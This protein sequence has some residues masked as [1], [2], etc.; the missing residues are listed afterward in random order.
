MT[1]LLNSYVYASSPPPSGATRWRVRAPTVHLSGD[2]FAPVDVIFIAADTAITMPTTGTSTGSGLIEGAY[3]WAFDSD[4][5]TYAAVTASTGWIE[6]QFSAA[7]D[8]VGVWLSS[9]PHATWCRQMP[10]QLI[11]EYYNG[12]SWVEV[13]NQT[14]I[15]DWGYAE[16]RKF[17]ATGYSASYTA[18]ARKYWRV[19]STDTNIAGD[20]MACTELELRATSG[21]SDQCDSATITSSAEIGGYEAS[22]AVDN[23]TS[24]FWTTG[25][26][27]PISGLGHYL[28]AV[29]GSDTS[30]NQITYQ[31]RPDTYREDPNNLFIDSSINGLGWIREWSH[32]SIGTWTAGETKTFTR[33]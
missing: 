13:I 7:Q 19:R 15:P 9:R 6:Y 31:V 16:Q 26:S 33:P 23:N 10:S 14:S 12:S 8:I 32:S 24:T 27:E 25:G 17:V 20:Y 1:M 3:E 2:G 30:V 29:F 11:V 18:A 28:Q 5:T 21:G 4:A 22:N